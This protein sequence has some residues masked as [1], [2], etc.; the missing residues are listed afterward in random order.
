MERTRT[1]RYFWWWLALI[2]GAG[3][4]LRVFVVLHSQSFLVGGDGFGYGIGANLFAQGH[5]FVE[6]FSPARPSA[7]H[8]PAWTLLLGIV[9]LLGG[10]S[11]IQQQL[12][13]CTIGTATVVVIG[14]AGRRIAGARVG[15]IGAGIGA[16]Y[17]GLW[18]YE[19]DLL[20][21]TLLLLGIAVTLVLAYRFLDAPSPW[22]ASGLGIMTALLALT[23]SEQIL[24]WAFLVVPLIVSTRSVARRRRVG[25]L[26]IATASMVIL[27]VPWTIYNLP[28]FQHVVLL[29]NNS[30]FAVAQGNCDPA[31]YGPRIGSYQPAC[32]SIQTTDQ[33]VANQIE[34][35][36]GVT[37][38]EHHLSRLPVVL[39]AREGRSFGFWNPFQQISIDSSWQKTPLWVNRMG[40]FT[41]WLL[42]V[43]ALA[44]VVVMRRR[45]RALYPLLAFVATVVV[46]TAATYG[47][48]RLR[49]PAEVPLVLLAA[50]GIDVGLRCMHSGG[51]PVVEA[52][53]AGAGSSAQRES[54][55][56]S[57]VSQRIHSGRTPQV[58]SGGVPRIALSA[59]AA[60]ATLSLLASGVTAIVA[61][62]TLNTPTFA[63]RVAVPSNG[64]TVS[65][66]QTLV[67]SVTIDTLVKTVTFRVES[68]GVTTNVVPSAANTRYGW[69]TRWDTSTVPA[70]TYL[71]WCVVSFY[72]G[73]PVTSRA[74][75][76]TVTHG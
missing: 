12:V 13:A 35:R 34:F 71:V 4:F 52:V 53:A 27:L 41:Y 18:I 9:A 21:E 49:A 6:P 74:I 40:L 16:V 7:Y 73:N 72:S 31:Y 69:L 67:A 65:N 25:W 59:V 29:S 19:R 60:V 47:E 24:V 10:H 38:A 37:Y 56:T 76:V 70:G 51:G 5:L 43:P 44:G 26:A 23:R 66:E 50:V 36:K 14:L 33:T 39:F 3:L 58:T 15:L 32:A 46:A 54:V 45:R 57:P 17:A 2:A 42:L 75:R 68:G 28:R 20:S 63:V 48:T 55:M 61:A 62:D 1:E 22:L 64:A 30:G 8:P 11:W